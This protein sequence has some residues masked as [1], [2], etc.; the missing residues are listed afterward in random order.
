MLAAPILDLYFKLLQHDFLGFLTHECYFR[1]DSFI[2]FFLSFHCFWV[3]FA[4]LWLIY[5]IRFG[6][7]SSDIILSFLAGGKLDE[8]EG[9][10]WVF[11]ESLLGLLAVLVHGLSDELEIN[12]SAFGHFFDIA[13]LKVMTQND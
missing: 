1:D 8:E 12:R 4:I 2:H 11:E 6:Q 3:Q 9:D 10:A 13:F 5:F 7:L